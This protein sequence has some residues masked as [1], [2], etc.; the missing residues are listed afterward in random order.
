VPSIQDFIACNFTIN[1]TNYL[2]FAS[3]MRY[4][5]RRC[6]KAAVSSKPSS[7][8]TK[9]KEIGKMKKNSVRQLTR[10]ALIA[11]LYVV[12]TWL[13]NLLGLASGAI[14]V[15]LSEAL[16]ILPLFFP[17]A[18]PGLLSAVCWPTCSPALCFG[19]FFSDPWQRCL[20][21]WAPLPCPGISRIWRRFRRF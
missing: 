5:K 4:D 13:A 17:E 19:T 21:R 16:T 9:L 20:A 14:Q 12:L 15:R 10:A 7:P 11:A 6:R 3:K 1:F 2:A 18:V 8:K